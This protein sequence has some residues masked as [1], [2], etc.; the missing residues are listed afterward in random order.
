MPLTTKW[1]KGRAHALVLA[2]QQPRARPA[3]KGRKEDAD[4]GLP[5]RDF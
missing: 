4:T 3:P 5:Q 2:G 1:C